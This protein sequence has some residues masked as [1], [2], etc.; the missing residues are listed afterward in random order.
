[1]VSIFPANL[2][3][4]DF[5]NW[6]RGDVRSA[7]VLAITTDQPRSGDGSLKQALTAGA[8]KSGVSFGF[9]AG[10][11]SHLLG[12]LSAVSY[13]WFRDVSSTNPD[14]QHPS[15]KL[16]V[17]GD[18]SDATTNDRV[19][20]VFEGA[21]NGRTVAPEGTWVTDV[22]TAANFWVFH[23]ATSGY[24]GAPGVVEVYDKTLAEWIAEAVTFGG[25]TDPIGA[26]AVVRGVA[27]ESGSGWNG[28]F[29]GYVDNVNVSFANASDV[30]ANFE[31][32]PP[33]ISIQANASAN[34]AEG[35]DPD[36]AAPFTTRNFAFTVSRTGDTSAAAAVDYAVTGSG[37]NAADAGD[38]LDNVLASGTVTFNAGQ[39]S[40]TLNIRVSEDTALE[41][42]EGFT[43]TLSNQSGDYVLG[44]ATADGLIQNDDQAFSVAAL[45]AD[46]AEGNTGNTPF[47]F[48]VSRTGDTDQAATVDYAVSSATANAADFGGAL[49]TGQ[50]SFAANE[51]SKTVTVNVSGDTDVEADEPF[52]VTLANQSSGTIAQATAQG[53]IRNDDS[54]IS[55]AA[56]NSADQAE[57]TDPDGAAPFTTRN[58][59]FTLSR[60]GD[61]SQAVTVNYA[62]TGSGA[63]A[64]DG[65]DFFNSVLPSG[66]WTLDAGQASRN[67]NIRVAE[68]VTIEPDE[69]FTVTLSNPTAGILDQATAEGTI[70]ND[71]TTIAIAAL[72]ADNAEGNSGNTPFTF[73]VTR[74]GDL[75]APSSV[76]YAVSGDVNAADFGGTLPS[77]TVNFNPN[78]TA[79]TVTLNVS[80]DAVLE[81]DEAFTV[82]LSAP[83]NA[84][85]G[86]AAAGGTIR[87]DDGTL[88]IVATNAI[89]FEGTDPD[90]SAPFTTRN[91]SFTVNRTGDRSPAVTL[92]YAVTG[93][94]AN[95]ADA[96][97]FFQNVLPAG[98]VTIPAGLLSTT[99]NVRV[100]QDPFAELDEGFTV[101][102][103][104]ASAG[105]IITG[106]AAGLIRNDDSGPLPPLALTDP[107]LLIA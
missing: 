9:A 99:L 93:S 88:S 80:G 57:G 18:G 26:N 95:P 103:T 49:P 29:T 3:D 47:T 20:M 43:V 37:A 83:V 8:D 23:S 63:N 91:F 2:T 54:G 34:R 66:T 69:G 48:T 65:A 55:I 96:N 71:D 82:T 67:F 85:L 15:L 21:Y 79:K 106:S 53:T 100:L 28:L 17:D 75:S 78:E 10:D 44:T 64:A 50:V 59:G 31:V 58:F 38:F 5:T 70:R 73:T 74:A 39:A 11:L 86:T 84:T 92:D 6:E 61:V 76:N 60:T 32:A 98:T 72:D 89:R 33:T 4:S 90:L 101:T 1:M 45:D 77:G 22:A 52:T 104:D 97:D 56:R 24:P 36:G 16:F 25:W 41:P 62:V 42:D 35:T 12:D 102:L 81:A 51:T 30:I 19:T 40:R 87:N 68:D 7:G 27:I 105:T 107:D 13:E 14:G 94:G 46:K